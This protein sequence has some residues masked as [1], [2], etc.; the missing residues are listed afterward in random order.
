VGSAGVET[1]CPIRA[2]WAFPFRTAFSVLLLAGLQAFG[3]TVTIKE[4]GAG[5]TVEVIRAAFKHIPVAHYDVTP[6][7]WRISNR[8]PM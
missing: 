2:K 6:R 1:A 5:E 3:A 8:T 7:P 4:P